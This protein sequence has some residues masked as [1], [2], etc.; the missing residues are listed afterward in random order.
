MLGRFLL[1]EADKLSL[2]GQ[3]LK[4]QQIHPLAFKLDRSGRNSA[5]AAAAAV[6]LAKVLLL[7][8]L[9]FD[10]GWLSSERAQIREK[11][12]SSHLFKESRIKKKEKIE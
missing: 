6:I 7:L 3:R 1:I 2:R 11:S 9:N 12:P 8:K 5:A 10:S 4:I